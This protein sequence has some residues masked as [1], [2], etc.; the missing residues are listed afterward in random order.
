MKLTFL[1]V[2]FP[3]KIKG[4]EADKIFKIQHDWCQTIELVS[5]PKVCKSYVMK[6][7]SENS[8]LK[9]NKQTC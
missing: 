2:G 9:T 8:K 1:G 5:Q 6:W 4:I 7:S 3:I